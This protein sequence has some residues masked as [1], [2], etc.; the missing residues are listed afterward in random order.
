MSYTIIFETKI[1]CLADGRVI[2]FSLQGCNNDTSGRSRDDWYGTLY[3]SREAFLK[4]T[5]SFDA[6]EGE[7][8]YA[9]ALKIG[10]RW[11]SYHQYGEHLRRMLKRSLSFSELCA[12][13]YSL[14]A[15]IFTGTTVRLLDDT[16]KE[17]TPEEWHKD[18]YDYFYGNIPNKGFTSHYKFSAN[19]TEIVELLSK[20]GPVSFYIGKKRRTVK[21]R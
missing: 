16:L 10:G 21:C 2:H 6:K 11:C 14:Y 5:H 8:D 9:D 13:P 15:K 1:C 17:F 7:T 20:K 12:T 4:Y 19:E 3:P 18:C